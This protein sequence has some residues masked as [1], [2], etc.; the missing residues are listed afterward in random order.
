[1]NKQQTVWRYPVI[2][3][4]LTPTLSREKRV[5]KTAYQSGAILIISLIML[6]LIT[7]IGVT[8]SQVT[9]LEEKMAGNM[10]EQNSAFQAAEAGLRAGETATAALPVGSCDGSGGFFNSV[11]DPAATSPSP[12]PDTSSIPYW[13][14]FNWDDNTH[15]TD[16]TGTF[17][18]SYYIERLN[19]HIDTVPT[20]TGTKDITTLWYRITARGVSNANNAI[21]L[22][23]STL[24]YTT[25]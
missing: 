9:G 22:L 5:I 12:C 16:P 14:T 15:Q 7:I 20:L 10:R 17:N 1:M 13:Q 21:V 25:E 8:G 4:A 24:S 19:D 11:T 6:L 18:Y 2:Q 3:K 23:Q